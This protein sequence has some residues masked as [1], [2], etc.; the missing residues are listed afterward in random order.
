M[1]NAIAHS[2]PTLSRQQGATLVVALVILAVL[3]I[4]GV[5]NSQSVLLQERMT[6]SVQD[7]HVAL[8]SAE[9]GV[10]EAEAFI[11]ANVQANKSNFSNNGQGGLA[12]LYTQGNGPSDIFDS[13]SWASTN[14]Q[15]ATISVHSD[16]PAP[17]FIIEDTGTFDEIDDATGVVIGGYGQSTGQGSINSFR[18]IVQGKGRSDESERYVISYYARRL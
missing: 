16:V 4:L 2:Q 11:E 8:Q 5:S 3:T 17:R 6:A 9:L 7:A 13:A 18:I 10:V 14:S 1:M 12:G 15:Q